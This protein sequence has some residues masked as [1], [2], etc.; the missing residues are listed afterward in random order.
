VLLL[1]VL[2]DPTQPLYHLAHVDEG[3]PSP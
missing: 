1:A 3:T 2:F